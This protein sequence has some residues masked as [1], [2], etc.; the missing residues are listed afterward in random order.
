MYL[1]FSWLTGMWKVILLVL[2]GIVTSFVFAVLTAKIDDKWGSKGVLT[3]F[4]VVVLVVC[5]IVSIR[6]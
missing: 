5:I 6:F 3:E 1:D 2:F 4:L